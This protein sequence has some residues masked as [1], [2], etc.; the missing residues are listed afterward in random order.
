[1]ALTQQLIVAFAGDA[2]ANGSQF[3]LLYF[4][5]RDERPLGDYQG[6]DSIKPY[7]SRL[8]QL[9]DRL[10][11]APFEQVDFVP[12]F[13]KLPAKSYY[14][15]VDS[16]WRPAGHDVVARRLFERLSA[17]IYARATGTV[18]TSRVASP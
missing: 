12:I 2:R 9:Q 17:D 8:A 15:V 5:A 16:H 6:D 1:V 3:V 7:V 14:Y 10:G 4:P 18:P 13:A 11:H